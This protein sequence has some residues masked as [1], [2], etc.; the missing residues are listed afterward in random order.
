[1]KLNM[2]TKE[3]K[4]KIKNIIQRARHGYS[5]NDVYNV[6][7]WFLNIMPKILKQLRDTTISAPLLPNT[8]ENT[9]HEEWR[10]ILSRMIFLLNE[11]D[12]DKCSYKN[13]FEEEFN[14][15]IKEKYSGHLKK[16]NGDL[17]KLFCGEEQN[18]WN[19][20][21]SCKREFFDLFSKYFYDLWD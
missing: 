9:C 14:H 20:I 15:Y 19:Y 11:M 5:D 3:I 2:K 8:D 4:N 13:P 7:M 16:S 21:N 17:E 10:N 12:E 6:D 1:M 18:K